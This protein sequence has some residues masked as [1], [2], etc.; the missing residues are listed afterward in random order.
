MVVATLLGHWE[1][2]LLYRRLCSNLL[3]HI[4]W[5]GYRPQFQPPALDHPA[6]E[7]SN[8]NDSAPTT[9]LHTSLFRAAEI[10][11]DS[12]QFTSSIC[13][14]FSFNLLSLV[15]LQSWCFENVACRQQLRLSW[16]HLP[17]PFVG[18][19]VEL[20]DTR[21]S[22]NPFSISGNLDVQRFDASFL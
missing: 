7:P 10:N 2:Y 16:L 6:V 4:G 9:S 15:V 5:N 17:L 22:P 20:T 11:L 14:Q 8:G 19:H 13:L 12:R 1:V 21:H 18:K 3:S